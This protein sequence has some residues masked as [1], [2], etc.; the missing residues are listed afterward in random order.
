M[1]AWIGD[2]LS[3][4]IQI[5]KFQDAEYGTHDKGLNKICKNSG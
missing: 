5:N 3:F 4:Y 1:L 2:K